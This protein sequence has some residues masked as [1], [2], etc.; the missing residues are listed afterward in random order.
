MDVCILQQ[1]GAMMV[2]RDM[3]ASP[4]TFLKASAPSREGIVVAVACLVTWSWL[5]ALCAQ[6]G[7]PLVLGH[8]LALQALHGGK[9]NNDRSDARK[10]AV[11]LRGGMLPQAAGSPATMRATRDLRRRR[12]SLMRQR[13]ELLPPIQH[14]NSQYTLPAMGTQIASKAN[15]DGVAARFPDPAGHQSIAVDRALLGHDAHLWRHM[16]WSILPTAKQHHPNTLSLLR[17]VPGIGAILRRVLRYAIHDIARCPRVQEFVAYCR[18]GTCAKASAGKRSGTSGTKRGHAYLQWACSEA[19]VVFLRDHPAGQQYRTRLEQ[20][21]GKGTAWTILAHTLARAVSCMLKRPT[22][23]EMDK[24]LNGSGRRAGAPDAS[25]DQ[26]GMSLH[27][28]RCKVC[29]LRR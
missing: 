6:E 5:A 21:P 29:S 22:A 1:D 27:S 26:D 14:T 2:P 13:A 4:D 8:A 16:A 3:Q 18:L 7:M 25:L 20:K 12:M 9:A 23:F 19:A 11:L 10:I 15:R 28:V 24:L 17:T